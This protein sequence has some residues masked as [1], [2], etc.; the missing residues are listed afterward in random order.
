MATW[1][2]YMVWQVHV[3]FLKKLP[4]CF[5]KLYH[6]IFT[7][8]VYRFS[9]F[10]SLPTLGMLIFLILAISVSVQGISEVLICI[11][12]MISRVKYFSCAY[13]P[14]VYL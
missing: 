6:F 10:T 13:L 12:L 1:Y 5:T 2:G 11:P 8:A 7:P 3:Y 9:S 4:N 14:S